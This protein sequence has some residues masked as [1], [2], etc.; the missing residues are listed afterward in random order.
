MLMKKQKKTEQIHSV[1]DYDL[2]TETAILVTVYR[3]DP[4][5]LIIKKI[6]EFYQIR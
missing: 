2:E 3:P 1:W 4:K 5:N 6:T